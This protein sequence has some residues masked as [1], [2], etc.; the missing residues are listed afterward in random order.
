MTG[1]PIKFYACVVNMMNGN[2]VYAS[3]D[4]HS[5][6]HDYIIASTAIPLV[7]PVKKINKQPYVDG[8]IREVAPL[9]Q[10][11]DN[12]ATDIICIVCQPKKLQAKKIKVGNVVALMERDM[13]IVTNETVNNDLDHC[14]EINEIL[15]HFPGQ[16]TSG[17]LKDKRHINLLVIRPSE[18][19]DLNLEDFNPKQIRRALEQGWNTS[20]Q[21]RNNC[22]WLNK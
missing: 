7:M 6:M 4:T 20:Q 2:A 8:G 12:D 5:N 19:V 14:D 9:R 1:S 10:A 3:V 16:P 22:D 11:I 15:K 18:P 21:A 17:P 13:D